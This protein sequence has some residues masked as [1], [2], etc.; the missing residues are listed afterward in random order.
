MMWQNMLHG[1]GH[2]SA[3]NVSQLVQLGSLV[4]VDIF[5][6]IVA[7]VVSAYWLFDNVLDGP[8]EPLF[9][10]ATNHHTIA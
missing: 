10:Q 1:I 5:N 6:V 8:V 7:L 2:I 9:L 4:R 3:T